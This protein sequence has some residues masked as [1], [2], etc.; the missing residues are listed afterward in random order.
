[1]I[2]SACDERPSL[3]TS[4][5]A[6]NHIAEITL[7]MQDSCIISMAVPMFVFEVEEFR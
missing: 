4:P 1:M 2:D 5:P 6:G 3:E 7:R